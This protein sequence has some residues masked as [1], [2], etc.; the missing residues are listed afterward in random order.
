MKI[1]NS[2][3]IASVLLLS[4][5]TI[6]SSSADFRR[7][8]KERKIYNVEFGI[9]TEVGTKKVE[10]EN[11]LALL[12]CD[13]VV[14]I[15]NDGTDYIVEIKTKKKPL[16]TKYREVMN[17]GGFELNPR[18]LKIND[19]DVLKSMNATIHKIKNKRIQ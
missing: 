12:D 15:E 6:F 16:F 17:A 11:V 13:E 2:L 3:V 10:V 4:S 8:E 9:I 1:I 7:V 5:F 19:L 18:F 14:A